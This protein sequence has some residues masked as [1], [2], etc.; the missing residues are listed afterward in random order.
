LIQE[1]LPILEKNNVVLSIENLY[2]PGFT[3]GHLTSADDL[4]FYMDY[5]KS[6]YLGICLDVGHAI[7]LDQDPVEMLR[8]VLNH[9]T[10]LHIHTS[11]PKQDLHAIPKFLG[12]AEKINWDEFYEVL[13]SGHYQGTFNLEL[14][15]PSNL[16]DEAIL[17]Y[18]QLAYHVANG[19]VNKK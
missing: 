2:G 8:K 10:A 15:Q 1:L 5:F 4:L 6:P 11:H 7:A 17:S 3:D 16:S 13:S 9:L 18:L 19:I 14:I 12:Y